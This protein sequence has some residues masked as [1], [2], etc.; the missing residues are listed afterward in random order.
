MIDLKNYVQSLGFQVVHIKTDSIKIPDAT[1]EIIK[2]V[3]EFGEGYGYTFE[4][5]ATYDKLC[6]VNDAVYIAKKHVPVKHIKPDNEAQI[7]FD[8]QWDAV[9]AQFQHPVVYKALF[10]HEPLDFNDLCETK[11]VS[12]GAMYL[13]FNESEATPSTPFRGM[14]FVGRSGLFVPVHQS[15]GGAKLV[16]VLPD[17]GKPYSVSGAKDYLWLEAEMIKTLNPELGKWTFDE[18][19]GLN[20]PDVT[21]IVDVRY[22]ENLV[23]DAVQTISKFGDFDEFVV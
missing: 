9:G 20:G 11:Q 15:A 21:N 19:V 4:H 12:K 14:H 6:L 13:D 2:Q 5:E 22:Y 10:T 1:P 18:L 3:E 7:L 16:R 17:N 23:N 8:V